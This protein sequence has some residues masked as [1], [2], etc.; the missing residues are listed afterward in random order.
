[1]RVFAITVA[2]TLAFG[3]TLSAQEGLRNHVT[4]E[5][6]TVCAGQKGVDV[7]VLI[8]NAVDIRHVTVPLVVRS[9]KGDAFV[10]TIK[11]SWGDRLPAAKGSPLSEYLITSLYS[12]RECQCSG[13]TQTG[14]GPEF[15]RDTL[16]NAVPG[17]PLGVL[18]TRLRM[19]GANLPAGKDSTGSAIM[20]FT[21]GEK[22]GTFEIDTTCICPSNHLMYVEQVSPPRGVDPGF[23][24]GVITVEACK[25]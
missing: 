14:F 4:V 17:S 20:T 16:E 11:Q 21:I 7:R 12:K 15:A 9:G 19:T 5:S 2:I 24:K 22:A 8:E 3:S 18:F 23:T 13:T 25:K 1:M 6:K 10:T